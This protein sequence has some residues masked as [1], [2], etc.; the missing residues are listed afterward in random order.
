MKAQ[1][2]SP[3]TASASAMTSR[4]QESEAATSERNMA[5]TYRD[6]ASALS[7]LVP[8]MTTCSPGLTPESSTVCPPTEPPFFTSRI[9]YPSPVEM[10]TI[11]LSPIM[12]IAS[13]G[14]L[15]APAGAGVEVIRTSAAKGVLSVTGDA[16]SIVFRPD[17]FARAAAGGRVPATS[18][19]SRKIMGDARAVLR[20]EGLALLEQV[21]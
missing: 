15:T 5:R 11:V 3:A 19:A 21:A 13:P 7:A 1:V 17:G 4:R 14:T 9:A 12:A 10:K 6:K 20:A 18:T 8:E 16:G 2:P